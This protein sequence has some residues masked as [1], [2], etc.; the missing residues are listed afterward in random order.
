MRH[1]GLRR[2]AAPYP[3][4]A[5]LHFPLID[6]IV[7]R[8]KPFFYSQLYGKDQFATFTSLRTQPADTTSAVAAWFDYRLKQKTNFERKLLTCIDAMC[9]AGG[10]NS[11]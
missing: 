4:A 3:G 6:S 8:L 10:R 11:K 1:T 5:D 9:M 7:E 2:I